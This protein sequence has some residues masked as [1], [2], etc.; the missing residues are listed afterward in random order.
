M[1]CPDPEVI[2]AL[3]IGSIDPARRE[4][5][6][7]HMES[8]DVCRETVVSL[9][10]DGPRAR[11]P[12]AGDK[13]GRY[14]IERRIGAGAMGVVFAA[15]DPDL[16]R[17]VAL[18]LLR[19]QLGSGE[20]REARLV[21][22]AQALARVRHPN[23][24]AVHD[25][26]TWNDR[27]F[28]AMELVE[29]ATLR[30]WLGERAPTWREIVSTLIEAGRGLVA[31]HEVGVIHRDFK[32]DNVLVAE[33]RVAVTDFGLARLAEAQ[34]DIALAATS[35]VPA[36]AVTQTGALLGTPAYM[37][38]EQ[39]SGDRIGPAADQFAFCVAAW[40]ALYG[41]RP[42]AGKSLPEL[43]GA[44]AAGRFAPLPGKSR[45]PRSVRQAL[46]R[47]L[48]ARPEERH[49]SMA[50]LLALLAP[51]RRAPW[52]AAAAAVAIAAISVIAWRGL[53][54]RAAARAPHEIGQ[55]RLTSGAE[56]SISGACISADGRDVAYV[57]PDGLFIRSIASGDLRRLSSEP[58][59]GVAWSPD[60]A[61]LAVSTGSV[62]LPD[63][64]DG[65][66]AVDLATGARRRLATG[67]Q[68]TFSPDSAELAYVGDRAVQVMRA[69]GSRARRVVELGDAGA[70][71][72]TWSPDGRR[73]AFGRIDL[74]RRVTALTLVDV[75]DGHAET[76]FADPG[77]SMPNREGGIAWHP[78]GRILYS[79]YEERS[80]TPKV[81]LWRRAPGAG[82]PEKLATWEGFRVRTF[83][84]ARATGQLAYVHSEGGYDVYA[85]SLSGERLDLARL[86]GDAADDLGGSF[87]DDDHL[88][89]SSTRTGGS[90]LYVQPIASRAARR[91][92]TGPHAK[93][94]P[95]PAPGGALLYWERRTDDGD[96]HLMR[97]RAGAPAVELLVEPARLIEGRGAMWTGVGIHCRPARCVLSEVDGGQI[98]FSELDAASGARR[99]LVTAALDYQL[100]ELD[101]AL[102]PDGRRAAL[103]DRE[104]IRLIALDGG[105][106]EE[107]ALPGALPRSVA[108]LADGRA[109]LVSDLVE[110]PTPRAEVERL[111]L[112]GARTVLWQHPFSSPLRLAVSPAG[113]VAA[114]LR[115]PENTLWLLD[116]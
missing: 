4:D 25:I 111:G 97:W 46:V 113:R 29:G 87:L 101:W 42:F 76:V 34:E 90:D 36:L 88:V 71:G 50:A 41:Q 107:L 51:R 60:R 82:A 54:H 6:T 74:A 28:V 5:V 109:L 73:L 105:G 81:T 16:D 78:D 38:P 15:R 57:T 108:W 14:L 100:A 92:A 62:Y 63:L 96:V 39:M 30:A 79:L 48:A 47:G 91:L 112:D 106:E 102:S 49:R 1:A 95:E 69:D 11:L 26:G 83:S 17:P 70:M 64:R 68:P 114:T 99:R 53:D 55:R 59:E 35:A 27:V 98:A 110:R 61:H 2:Q 93:V 45:V 44:I 12:T 94:R 37:A 33:T 58:A 80:G 66:F 116:P 65:I 77:L 22:E 56:E 43:R 10:G 32:A 115:V 103:P 84:I 104:R 8:C 85:G 75:A 72:L 9:V 3:V 31:A 24:V 89:F 19:D 52:I 86:T 40:E 67:V 23:V 7:V 20:E 18:K 21:R 13:V